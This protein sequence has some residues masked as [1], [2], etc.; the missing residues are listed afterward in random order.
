MHN[1]GIFLFI[2]QSLDISTIPLVSPSA[3]GELASKGSSRTLRCVLTTLG[4]TMSELDPLENFKCGKLQFYKI[5]PRSIPG[6]G[7]PRPT[8]RLVQNRC[9][10]LKPDKA[11][12][13]AGQ[14]KACGGSV[15]QDKGF[16]ALPYTSLA[17]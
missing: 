17:A 12:T 5:F 7:G 9:P 16:F 3:H 15:R 14:G 1:Q 4:R 6:F 11:L 10:C 2:R 8:A 13:R